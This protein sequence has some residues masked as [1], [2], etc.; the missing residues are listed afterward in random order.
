[1]ETMQGYIM[2]LSKELLS[3]VLGYEIYD[4]EIGN[5]G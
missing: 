4:K 5:S 3:E 2:N 1:M